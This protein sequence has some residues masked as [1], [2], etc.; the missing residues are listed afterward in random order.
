MMTPQ[1]DWREAGGADPIDEALGRRPAPGALDRWLRPLRTRAALGLAPAA[2]PAL[3]FVPLG[4]LLGPRALNV[5]SPVAL[6]YLDTVVSV[7]LAVL[8]V[9]VGLAL[10]LR[11]TRDRSLL[12][13]A[14]LEALLTIAM[15]AGAFWFLLSEWQ[16]PLGFSPIVI[17]LVL[18]VC[19]AASSAVAFEGLSH[20]YQAVASRIADLDDVLPIVL[21]GFLIAHLAAP[22]L[23][24]WLTSV[25]DV[26]ITLGLGVGVGIAGWLLFERAHSRAE[27]NVFIAGTVALLGG[28]TAYLGLSPLLAGLAAGVLWNQLPGAAD[29]VVR[30][31]LQKIQHPLIVLLLLVAGASCAYSLAAVWLCAPLVLFR[32][33][34]KFAG[35]WVASRLQQGVTPADLGAYLIAPGL[36]GIAFALSVRQALGGGGA[37][38][39]L[40]AVVVATLASEA[41]AFVLTPSEE[42]DEA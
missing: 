1:A 10:K 18:G 40:T 28:T 7:A 21:G 24:P 19:A 33:A 39:L 3:L 5:L 15:V 2:A 14:S 26:L 23:T 41:L 31:D 30:E 27:R 42:G 25:I 37:T 32:L 22:P 34:G 8:G 12:A 38:A 20:A 35:G 4:M 11:T 13:A 36:L 17:G 9:F 16:M 6:T 29:S